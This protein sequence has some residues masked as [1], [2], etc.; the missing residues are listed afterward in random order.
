MPP[1]RSKVP[2]RTLGDSTGGPTENPLRVVRGARRHAEGQAILDP[3]N[4][5]DLSKVWVVGSS[6]SGKTTLARRLAAALG[7]PRIELDAHYWKADWEPRPEDEFRSNVARAIRPETWVVDGNY[8]SRL[9]GLVWSEATAVVWLDYSFPRVFGRAL[10]RTIRRVFTRQRVY[11]GNIE[12]FAHAFLSRD[13]ILWWVIVSW[14]RNRHQ[15]GELARQ[16]AGSSPEFI[17]FRHPREAEAWLRRRER[18]SG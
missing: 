17:A 3:R 11:S 6:C 9:Q 12:T 15:I 1:A 5:A 13:S 18:A 2:S 4:E 8:R 16:R 14:R 7:S 10:R